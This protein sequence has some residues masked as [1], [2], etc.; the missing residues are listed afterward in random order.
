MRTREDLESYLLDAGMAHEE[1]AQNTWLVRDPENRGGR[2]VVRLEDDLVL[3]RLNVLGLDKV[4]D[5]AQ[6]FEKLLR[7]NAADMVHG[8]YGLADDHVVLTSIMLLE[9]L[10]RAE[11]RAVLDDFSLALGK[12]R[13]TLAAFCA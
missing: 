3:F 8:A 13:E 1:V 2:I 10:D 5:R 11:F 9:T 12:H 4:K 6:L 7:L